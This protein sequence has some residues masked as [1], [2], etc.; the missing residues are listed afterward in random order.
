[1]KHYSIIFA[2]TCLLVSLSSCE[3]KDYSSYPP[4]WKGFQFTCNG[5]EVNPR[6]GIH[7][8]DKI[9]VTALQD[10]KGHLIN[11]TTYNWEVI[12]PI[13]LEDGLTYK[14]SVFFKKSVHT[15]YDGYTD[16]SNDPSIAFTIPANALGT[17]TVKFSATYAYSGSGI[18]VEDGG[19]Y[20]SGSG[21]GY[22]SSSSSAAYG[23][24]NGSARFTVNT[25]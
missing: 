14:D 13:L 4:T 24:A 21:S 18:Q 16:G 5:Q 17:A 6:T 10:Q 19:N 8:G 22:I 9:I 15:N 7:A 25:K 11:G 12:A 3:K 23:K 2:V 20:E 1:M